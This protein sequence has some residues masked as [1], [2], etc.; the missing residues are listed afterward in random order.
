MAKDKYHEHVRNALI[1]D[2]WTITHDPYRLPYLSSKEQEIDLGAEKMVFGAEKGNEQIAVEVKSFTADSFLQDLYKSV[3]QYLIYLSGLE[4][5]DP[6]RKLFLAV[7]QNTFEEE[8]DTKLM[9]D[10]LRKYDIK[11][12]VVNI[13]NQTVAQWLT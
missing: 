5:E 13:D 9:R 6:N 4:I 11:I 10:L 2:G 3:G 1:K 12:V 7:P 8:F